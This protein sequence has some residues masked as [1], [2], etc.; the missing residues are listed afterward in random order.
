MLEGFYEDWVLAEREALREMYLQA[1][2]DLIDLEKSNGKYSE[3]LAHA[4]QLASV[5]PLQEAYHR[6]VMRLEFWLQKPDAALKQYALC[7]QMLEEQLGLQPDAETAALAQE[8]ANRC[9]KPQ[10]RQQDAAP[11]LPTRTPIT[12][13]RKN[14]PTGQLPLIGREAERSQLNAILDEMLDGFGAI[15]LI[16]GEAGVGKT[17]LVQEL[18]GDAEW[19][20]AQVL[21]GRSSESEDSPPYDP[22]LQALNSGLTPLRKEELTQLMQPIWLSVLAPLLPELGDNQNCSEKAAA[23]PPA[24]EHD[25]LFYAF[26][27]LLSAWGEIRPL[28]LILENIHW[29]DEDSLDLLSRLGETAS[30]GNILLLCTYRSEEGRA[31]RGLWEKLQA[32][33][34][35]P[36]S[37]RI[38]L[39]RLNAQ[40]S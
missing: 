1:L 13:E 27:Q 9:D 30:Q 39:D 32:I 2:S 10:A 7:C 23:L 12:W 36:S 3:A 29:L 8:I 31:Q 35:Q 22:L 40:A 11:Y 38:H 34:R 28:V 4:L 19:R 37:R 17:R 5:E 24:Q 15:A 6:E 26:S 18:A 16:D 21:W 20:S 14:P 25:R 33:H